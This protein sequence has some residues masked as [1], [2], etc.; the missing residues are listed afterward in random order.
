MAAGSRPGR[1]TD[2][3]TERLAAD[4]LRELGSPARH[5]LSRRGVLRGAGLG[6]AGLSTLP[7]LSACGTPGMKQD[8]ATCT[9]PDVSDVDRKL[10]F[11]NWPLYI[12]EDGNRL[13]TLEAFEKAND[14]AVT[15]QTDINDN[16]QFFAK[17][18]MQLGSCEPI[19]RDIITLTDWMA[20][21]L[22]GLGWTQ[23]LN[24][25]TI[26]NVRANLLETLRHPQWDKDRSFSVPWQSGLT[27]VAY[28]AKYT[29]EITSFE[30]LVTRPDLKGKISLLREMGDTM[31]F[32]LKLVDADPNDFTEE[33][34]NAAIDRLQQVVDSGQVRQFTG[35]N[36]TGP[37]NKGDI[38]AC[39]A[40]SGDIMVMQSENPDIRFVVPEE[41]LSLWSDNMLVPN[42]A[43]HQTNAEKLMNYYYEPEVAATLAA[44]VWYICPVQ[45]AEAAMEK[46]DPSLVGNP[47]IFPT[48]DDLSKTFAFMLVPDGIR[49]AYNKQFNRVIGA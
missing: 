31:G 22:V 25:D 47:L 1:R 35:N 12:D 24:Q 15:Y 14:I 23:P 36:Y 18:R 2:S 21:R 8:P 48:A 49:E 43:T 11:S 40:W 9:A 10:V 29:G 33:E 4:L 46:I 19:N 6:A 30:E 39:E 34:W 45:G 3:A 37:L 20:G 44:W 13:P 5:P 26:P 17:I 32:F 38:V 7:L 42:K 16:N 28:N 41:G 27:G